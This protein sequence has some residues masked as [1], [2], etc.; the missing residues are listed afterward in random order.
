MFVPKRH[1]YRFG[2]IVELRSAI[3][4]A[5]FP[6]EFRSHPTA[7]GTVSPTAVVATSEV[8][9]TSGSR[10]L[11]IL[12][13]DALVPLEPERKAMTLNDVTFFPAD[14]FGIGR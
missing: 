10:T 3:R 5:N 12:L 9:A 8:P 4:L 6:C 7:A 2:S 1:T 11:K 13:V 14:P